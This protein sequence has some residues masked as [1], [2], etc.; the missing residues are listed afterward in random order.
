MTIR[1]SITLG[2][3]VLSCARQEPVRPRCAP[4]RGV[5]CKVGAACLE[6]GCYD[7]CDGDGARCSANEECFVVRSADRCF[8]DIVGERRLCATAKE[9]LALAPVVGGDWMNSRGHLLVSQTEA[10]TRWLKSA[11]TGA[12]DGGCRALCFSDA[13]CTSG[14]CNCIDSLVLDGGVV[15][16]QCDET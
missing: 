8:A 6:G 9:V 13:Q 16:G 7:S 5:E 15:A 14:H 11:R 2:L 3:A 10:E 12:L 4:E 1:D